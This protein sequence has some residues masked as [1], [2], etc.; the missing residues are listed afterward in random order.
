MNDVCLELFV[1]AVYTNWTDG[2]KEFI[3]HV[4]EHVIGT[5]NESPI[6]FECLISDPLVQ[7]LTKDIFCGRCKQLS[8]MHFIDS[9]IEII[10]VECKKCKNIMK[11]YPEGKHICYNCLIC[12]VC[13]HPDAQNI[14]NNKCNKC[15]NY[16]KCNK[17]DSIYELGDNSN[18]KYCNDCK[19]VN[20][21]NC[22][23]QFPRTTYLGDYFKCSRCKPRR[24]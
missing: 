10:D 24:Y 22:N 20:C 7:E 1:D 16:K 5:C 12:T 4:Y 18:D 13:Y 19:T 11:S 2:V 9:D 6:F 8:I 23:K 3:Q 17:C 14:K 15:I 21:N